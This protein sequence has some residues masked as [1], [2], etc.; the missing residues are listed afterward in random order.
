MERV[1]LHCDC[2]CFF[3]S[4]E[5]L[6]HPELRQQ[7]VAVCGDPE[8]RHGIILA[9]NEPAKAMGIK[10]AETIWQARRK[11]PQLVLLPAH[12]DR[13]RL[14][15]DRI[16]AI[17]ESYTDLVEPFGIDESWLDVTG[18]LHLF[19]G[20]PAALA[21]ELRRRIR[22]EL[23]LTVSVGVSFNKVFAKLGSD[24]KKPDATT[25]ITRENFRSIVWPLPVGDLLYAGRAS[26]RLLEQYGVR[27][28]GEL[29]HF[30]RKALGTLMGKQGEQLWR[31]AN[32]LENAPVLPAHAY[33]PPKSVGNGETFPKDLT[34]AEEVR[35]GVVLLT[36][37]VATRLRRHGMKATTLQVS[38]RDPAFRDLCRQKPLPSPTYVA[39]ELADTALELIACSWK[40]GSP[41]RAI[42]VTAS[43]LIPETESA[44][45]LDL[46]GGEEVRRRDR[47]ERLER[48]VDG[49]REK[50]GRDAVHS[51]CTPL[52]G[53]DDADL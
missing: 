47:L 45:Q 11:C 14:Y 23:G 48:T 22:V 18:S 41:L 1:I 19:G 35:R 50:Y 36:D 17:Y 31:Y 13:Y 42:T 9:K 21:D 10:T 30:D 8:A 27:T 52:S 20:D 39:R 16:N 5:L 28:I 44:Q 3:A 38:L 6:S 34:T 15:S 26:V 51:A 4:V 29:A 24:Y 40:P 43:G 2:N 12:H 46:F 49:L 37:R 25:V 7:P 53:P 32:G 33:V